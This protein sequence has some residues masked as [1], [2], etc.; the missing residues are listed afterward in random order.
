MRTCLDSLD[1]NIAKNN[2][3]SKSPCTI[4]VAWTPPAPGILKIN[5]DGSVLNNIDTTYLVTNVV[6]RTYNLSTSS[7]LLVEA[8]TLRNG[9]LLAIENNVHHVYI[10]GDNLLIINILQGQVQCPWK[11][12]VLIKDVKQLLNH[13]DSFSSRTST[14]KPMVQQIMLP[15]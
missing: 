10:E 11:I 6:S 5:F 7:P 15:L 4:K 2:T 9:L 1:V 13:F 12:Q 8:V 3:P 14:K